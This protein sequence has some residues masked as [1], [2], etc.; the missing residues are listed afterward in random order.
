MSQEPTALGPRGSNEVRRRPLS[1]QNSSVVDGLGFGIQGLAGSSLASERNEALDVEF[2]P[3]LRACFRPLLCLAACV[4]LPGGS[5][6]R[7][8]DDPAGLALDEIGLR[9]ATPM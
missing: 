2:L 1:R 7:L 9:Q 4:T 8:G 3:G 6:F 5:R